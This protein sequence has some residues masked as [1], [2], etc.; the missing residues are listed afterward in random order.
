VKISRRTLE[1]IVLFALL[2]GVAFYSLLLLGQCYDANDLLF[3]FA[4]WRHFLK[5][6]LAQG[7]IPLWNPYS[8]CGQPFFADLQ[9]QMLYPP[10]W[11]T[12]LPSIPTG[13]NG[14]ILLHWF[15]AAFGMRQWL[16]SLDL[17][18]GSSRVG[19]LL[20]AF[21]GFF[22]WEIIHPP[23]L[24]AFAWVPWYFAALEHFTHR[25]TVRAGW[26]LGASY[27]M[28]FLS[29]SFQVTLGATYGGV[30]YALVRLW[31]NDR[32]ETQPKISGRRWI[33]IGMAILL[34]G[35]ILL[36]QLM[37]T[38]QF[39]KL[40]V[41]ENAGKNYDQFNAY[42]SLQPSTLGQFLFPRL[43]L[44][45]DKTIES[46]IQEV[47]GDGGQKAG[48]NNIGNDYLANFG[49][50]GVWIPLLI[51][52]AFRERQRSLAIL[53]GAIA[54]LT[55]LLCFGKFFFLHSLLCDLAPG[56]SLLRTPFRFLYMY[57]L[58]MSA[59]AAMGYQHLTRDN[60]PSGITR[61]HRT[62]VASYAVLALLFCLMDPA[63]CWREILSLAFVS[64]GVFFL[65]NPAL[66]RLGRSFVAI[67]LVAPLLLSGWGDFAVRPSS[68]LQLDQNTPWLDFVKTKSQNDRLWLD[69]Q[70]PYSINTG[71]QTTYM[72][73]PSNAACVWRL[74]IPAGYNPLHLQNFADIQSLPLPVFSKL[75]ALQR[76]FFLK[77]QGGDI[78][79]Y[80][81]AS[82][83][84]I[85]LYESI[86]PRPLAYAPSHWSIEEDSQKSLLQLNN[87]SFDPY[88][89]SLLDQAPIADAPL[90]NFLVPPAFAATLI[91]ESPNRQVWKIEV[92]SPLI[93]VFTDSFYPG[94]IAKVD[95]LTTPILKANH[96][97][98]ALTLP[99][100]NH[101][102]E[103]SFES[104]YP[105]YLILALLFWALS[106]LGLWFA[107]RFSN[108]KS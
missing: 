102:V 50:L 29:G 20:F 36:P 59:L 108:L 93:A 47:T 79:G 106:G 2:G 96:G 48:A 66:S 97:F 4:P 61:F 28:L 46:A 40:S 7:I 24:A 71:S 85:A 90:P 12:L 15:I 10:N 84:P 22:W 18:E 45:H 100:G 26:L 104:A 92:S 33:S 30:L 73:V 8:F 19:A 37:A 64:V 98:R 107:T 70:L 56:F 95:G 67:G 3:Q 44:S 17:S 101:Q 54:A 63:Q 75:T 91:S 5:D 72:P 82:E 13:M 53:L 35:L 57:I 55:L 51:F 49:Y 39:S 41:R 76:L 25:P 9:T 80:A 31:K 21:S 23:V 27:A 52:L 77:K 38:Q 58:P 99:T 32:K 83:N 34:G 105:Y 6:S 89:M 86:E 94:W 43:G 1:T 65:S 78:P 74:K 69:S 42:W 68:N 103:F 14:F 16:R 11:L 81:L 88:Q 60:L 87:P 62:L